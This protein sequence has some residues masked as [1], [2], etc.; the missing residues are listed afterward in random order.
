MNVAELL[1]AQ[2]VRRPDTPAILESAAGRD[3]AVS[4]ADL[5]RHAAQL[6]A[7]FAQ[8]GLCASDSV[9]LML[10]L[11]AELFAALTAVFR[12]GLLAVFPDLSGGR[13]SLEQC[14]ALR[15]PAAVVAHPSVH[16]L[17]VLSRRF[18]R[19][20]HKFFSGMP[21]PGVTSLARAERFS[22]LAAIRACGPDMPAL[23][24]FT[25]GSTGRPKAVLRTHGR[26]IAQHAS[27]AECLQPVPGEACL[28]ALPL[29]A[30]SN[31][32]AGMTTIIPEAD[33][34]APGNIDPA[35]LLAQIDRL[36]PTRAIGP[37]ALFERLADTCLRRGRRLASLS[38]IF[39]G[40]APVFPRLLDK[41]ASVAPQ[42]EISAVYGSTEAEPIACLA[43]CQIAA[44]DEEAMRAGRGVLAGRPASTVQVR[45][46][47]DRWGEPIAP[48]T[49]AEFDAMALGPG[50]PGEIVVAGPHVL[51]GYL[52]GDGDLLSKFSVDG[53]RWH[54]T[55]DAGFL[56]RQG[57]LWLLGRCVARLRDAR[58]VLYPL[59]I[60]CAAHHWP[61]IRRA[62][63]ALHRG[64]RVLLL[65]AASR[66]G[67]PDPSLLDR[68][69]GNGE[70]DAFLFLRRIPVDRRHNSKV[71]Y[72]ALSDLLQHAA[73][74]RQPH[75]LPRELRP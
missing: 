23:L 27:L 7:L 75:P 52:E 42:A 24:T 70:I 63:L 40:G 44:A 3:R 64:R 56:D 8:A 13:A 31:L 35:P 50:S 59:G 39:T 62:A 73:Q 16:L 57:R 30:L 32:A 60:E 47:P 61:G 9:L 41:L 74:R 46:L 54:R 53:V 66:W 29:F 12:L 25:S 4:F 1:R 10:P 71:D 22:P 51:P 58:G 36:K 48:R 19:I 20:P 5:E 68:L 49:Q 38:R 45:I 17:G 28:T 72:S 43:R 14:C 26:L 67:R 6:A 33:L 65:E 55:G 37:P 15:P 69:A 11:G 2:A 34:R 18:R 21:L